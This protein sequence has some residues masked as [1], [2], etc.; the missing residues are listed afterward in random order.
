LSDTYGNIDFTNSTNAKIMT[1]KKTW[2]K[3]EIILISGDIEKTRPSVI[4]GTYIG[5]RA[6]GNPNLHTL[7]FAKNSIFNTPL[8]VTS[9]DFI[10]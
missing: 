8:T 3:P 1:T 6:N 7:T 4:E 2:K 10:S 5:Q 9:Q